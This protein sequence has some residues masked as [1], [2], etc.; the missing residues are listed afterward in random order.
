MRHATVIV[1][2]LHLLLQAVIVSVPGRVSASDL[3]HSGTACRCCA[4]ACKAMAC[5]RPES[6]APPAPEPSFPVRVTASDPLAG[7][8]DLP[9]LALLLP[10]PS[11][12]RSLAACRRPALP[13]SVPRFL[14]GSGFLG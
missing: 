2:M 4:Q 13:P 6:P 12:G 5:C 1:L 8:P 9:A 7:S 10:D 14:C 3:A 11:P